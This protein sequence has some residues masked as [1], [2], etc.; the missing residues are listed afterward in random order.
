MKQSEFNPVQ[1]I[2]NLPDQ[3]DLQKLLKVCGGKEEKVICVSDESQSV[4][5]VSIVCETLGILTKKGKPVN[6]TVEND[7]IS[8]P[9]S[10]K[11][12]VDTINGHTTIICKSDA[13][14]GE[15]AKKYFKKK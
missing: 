11:C 6:I 12:R 4:V 5:D 7:S 14:N 9:D 1:G 8:A 10:N 2:S 13:L 15:A 3:L